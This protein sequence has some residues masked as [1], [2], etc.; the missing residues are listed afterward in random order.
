[1]EA[2]RESLQSTIDTQPQVARL[3][4]MATGA[5]ATHKANE[6]T[7]KARVEAAEAKARNAIFEFTAEVEGGRRGQGDRS[8]TG[9]QERRRAQRA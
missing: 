4:A 5:L 8:R 7:F 3:E 6:E 9:E 1:M 2:G